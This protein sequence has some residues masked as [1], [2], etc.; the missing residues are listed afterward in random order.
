MTLTP[1][2]IVR[3]IINN[4][5]NEQY[6]IAGFLIWVS[7]TGLLRVTLEDNNFMMTVFS[8]KTK[9]NIFHHN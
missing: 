2:T 6:L 9:V 5:S 4:M 1:D 3:N 8:Q 7:F